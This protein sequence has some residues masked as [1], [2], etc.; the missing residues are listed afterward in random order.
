M[1]K[2]RSHRSILSRLQPHGTAAA[3]LLF[4]SCIVSSAF[5]QTKP[6][7]SR[8]ALVSLQDAF[9]SVADEVEPTVVTV[10]A[11]RASRGAAAFGGGG[12]SVGTGTG[13]IVRKDGWILT[14]EHVVSG[15]DRVTVK[16]HD[17]REFSGVTYADPRSDLAVIKIDAH[18]TLPAAKLGDSDKVK[19]GQWAIAIGSPFKYEG[20]LSVGVIS[21]LMRKQLIDDPSEGVRGKLYPNMIQTDAAINP[22]NSGGPLCNLAGEIIGINTA[23]QSGQ[24]QGGSIGIGFAIPMN[25]A[26]FV[27]NQLIE[28]GR[29]AYGFLGVSPSTVTPR[30]ATALKV[31]SGALV[32]KDPPMNSPAG[33]AG[34]KAGD[35]IV[36]I[37][38]K[39]VRSEADLRAIIGQAGPSAVVEVKLVRDG[40]A[41]LVSATLEQAEDEP[42]AGKRGTSAKG[43]LGL[44]VEKLS[45]EIADRINVPRTTQGVL[46]KSI[47][48]NSSAADEED[49]TEGSVILRINDTDTPTIEAF[50]Q[51]VSKLK[52]GDTIRVSYLKADRGDGPVRRFT[53]LSV[54]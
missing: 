3:I 50:N 41:K 24:S 45:D 51:A 39:P 16:L 28:K 27:M 34:I 21:S 8:V 25:S 6:T 19:V 29:V 13:V 9:V 46:L 52:P 11:S 42:L 1:K 53:V 38:G 20:S 26:R 30:Q 12:R 18:E 36:A 31:D 10:S 54:D 22:G 43:K 37:A 4:N 40:S 15:A 44:E 17:G 32:Y 5:S 23:I 33:K 48:P 49:F 7:E 2:L 14:N 35:V 47:D